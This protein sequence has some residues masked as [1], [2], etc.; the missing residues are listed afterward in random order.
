MTNS[1]IT[2]IEPKCDF[3]DR[4]LMRKR[5]T[6]RLTLRGKSDRIT[7]TFFGITK[8]AVLTPSGPNC[9]KRLQKDRR[10]GRADREFQRFAV[11][12]RK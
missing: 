11:F 10:M 8:V 1:S 9:H 4:D 2:T 6:L 12:A 3:R 7:N 5:L